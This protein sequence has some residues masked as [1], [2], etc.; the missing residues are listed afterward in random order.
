MF[1]WQSAPLAEVKGIHQ[2]AAYG[3]GVSVLDPRRRRQGLG[4]DYTGKKSDAI[5]AIDL[6]AFPNEK[7]P[8]NILVGVMEPGNMQALTKLVGDPRVRIH[9]FMVA[10]SVTPWVWAEVLVPTPEVER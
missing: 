10:T 4:R 7:Q 2:L 8:V 1:V 3:V 9:Q 5:L 6:R